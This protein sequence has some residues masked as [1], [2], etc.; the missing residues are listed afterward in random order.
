LHDFTQAD[1]EN[2]HGPDQDMA[3]VD[4]VAMATDPETLPLWLRILSE[5][6]CPM[7]G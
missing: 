5:E 3:P 7:V 6:A 1:I 2:F 4:E